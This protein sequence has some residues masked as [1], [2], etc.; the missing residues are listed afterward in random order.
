[1]EASNLQ[2]H[3]VISCFVIG[4]SVAG[5]AEFAENAEQPKDCGLCELCARLCAATLSPLAQICAHGKN[6]EIFVNR[7]LAALA[8]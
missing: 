3:F 7:G 5:H 1:M 8:V 4:D 2:A 6:L